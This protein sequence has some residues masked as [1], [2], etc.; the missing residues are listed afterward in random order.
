MNNG[1]VFATGGTTKKAR[2]VQ[3]AWED[4]EFVCQ[5]SAT[6]IRPI[7]SQL[8]V[9]KIANCMAAGGLWGGFIFVQ[10][11]A[12][13]TNRTCYPF[14]SSYDIEKLVNHIL[15]CRI[16]TLI[17]LPN[18][19]VRLYGYC[20]ENDIDIS[21][22]KTIFYFGEGFVCEDKRFI[23]KGTTILPLTY[24]TQETGV[25][26]YKCSSL[27]EQEYHVFR[28][29]NAYQNSDSNSL[30]V[31]L[32]FPSGKKVL[33]HNTNDIVSIR[34]SHKCNCGFE[35]KT[36]I[37]HGREQHY[38]NIL[39]T[40]ISREEIELAFDKL[41]VGSSAL[42]WRIQ[43]ATGIKESQ[44]YVT[45]LI[46]S[47]SSLHHLEFLDIANANSLINELYQDASIATL[48]FTDYS[49]FHCH[50]ISGKTPF[51]VTKNISA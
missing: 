10:E 50:P 13:I 23:P 46:D 8:S 51:H 6:K 2:V 20:A 3:H 24:T 31:D 39:G 21:C 11:V 1:I 26:G 33:A 17:A 47:D 25:L 7:F 14:S 49:N 41:I 5:Q 18:Y 34:D 15:D 42:I 45:I 43:I 28:H 32:E 29:V 35:G 19:V 36:L 48:T 40:S 22:L 16:D 38:A 12:K 9:E 4:F 27:A 30:V 44:P 37:L